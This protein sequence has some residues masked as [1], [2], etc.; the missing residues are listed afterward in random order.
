MLLLVLILGLLP[1]FGWLVFYLSEDTHPE[2]K[3]LIL[4]TFMAGIVFALV[5]VII[6]QLF[7]NAA[8]GIGIQEFSIISLVGLALIEEAMKFAAAYFVIGK[9]QILKD[10]ID[11]MIYIIIAALGFATLENIGAIANGSAQGTAIIATLFE[12]AS[13]RFVGAT[14]LH[15][16]TSGIVGYHWA[17]GIARKKIVRG[18][19]LGIAIATILH[20]CFNYLILHYGNAMYSLVFLVLVGFFV[21][22]DFEKLR[23]KQA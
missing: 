4:L 2:P 16:L 14:L 13:L 12:T 1:G 22:N 17:L 15:S 5:T 6:E 20:A 10:P 23:T 8:T 21:L 3:R 19:L 9:S 7:N 11:V 18:I